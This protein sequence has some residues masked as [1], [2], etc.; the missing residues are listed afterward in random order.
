MNN[1][2]RPSTPGARSDLHGVARVGRRASAVL[3]RLQPGDIAVLDHPDLD[4]TSAQDLIDAG[5]SAVVNATSLVSGRFP[6]IGPEMLAAAGVLLVDRIGRDGVASIRD[7]RTLHLSDGS[8]LVGD[9]EVARGRVVSLELVREELLRAR[10][11]LLAQLD[12]LTHN[13][14][15]FLRREQDLVLNGIGLPALTTSIDGRPVVVVAR[16]GDHEAELL[17]VHRFVREQNP[18]LIAVDKAADDVLDAGLAPHVVVI[19]PGD[20]DTMPTMDGLRAADDVVVCLERGG[21]PSMIDTLDRLGAHP[22]RCET[23]ATAEDVALLLA[24]AGHASLVV[25]V[26]VHADLQELLDRQ[27]AGLASTYLTRLKLGHT[28]VD[29]SSI[30]I[31]YTGRVRTWHVLAVVLAGWLA[32]GVALSVTPVGQVWLDELTD[33]LSGLV[34]TMQGLF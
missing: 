20:P 34:D 33:W 16:A 24:D 26:G 32:L 4:R 22:L 29:A 18:V 21:Q 8:V 13:A 19:S 11:G 15:E 27:R 5:V 1:T 12:T 2:A 9:E 25:G 14:A 6:S 31:L 10:S 7:A 28:L 23:S 17:T 30:P 3:T